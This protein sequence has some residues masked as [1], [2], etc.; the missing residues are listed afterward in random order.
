MLEFRSI[1][2]PTDFSECAQHAEHYGVALAKQFHSELHYLYAIEPIDTFAT[3]NGVEQSIY[4][5][6]LKDLR[7]SAQERL[8]Q[9]AQQRQQEGFRVVTTIREGRAS[10]AIIEYAQQNAISLICIATHGR[11]GFSHLILGSTTERV[12]RRAP[13]PVFVVRAGSGQS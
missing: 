7:E 10:E 3:I 2:I 8:S 12:V 13:C 5:D 1:L 9:L 11:R 4:F 6:V